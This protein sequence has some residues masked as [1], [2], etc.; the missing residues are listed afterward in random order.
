[1][2]ATRERRLRPRTTQGDHVFD[3]VRKLLRQE[4]ETN[5]RLHETCAY[6][7]ARYDSACEIIAQHI[8]GGTIERANAMV[9]RYRERRGETP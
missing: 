4:N 8:T 6:L 9:E 3:D 2:E 5:A 1:V 7:Q